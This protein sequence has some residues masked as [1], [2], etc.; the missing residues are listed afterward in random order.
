MFLIIDRLVCWTSK[1]Q[2]E[3]EHY[4]TRERTCHRLGVEKCQTEN[5]SFRDHRGRNK[6]TKQE[7]IKQTLIN[8]NVESQEYLLHL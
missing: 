2:R 3:K 6:Q 8:I 7:I 4:P 1:C 5:N